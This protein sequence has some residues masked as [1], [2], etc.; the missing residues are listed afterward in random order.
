IVDMADSFQVLLKAIT[1]EPDSKISALS[2]DEE[3]EFLTI[4]P[5]IRRNT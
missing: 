4:T 2:I 1:E 3:P 5:I